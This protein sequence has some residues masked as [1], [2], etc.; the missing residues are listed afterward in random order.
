[1]LAAVLMTNMS[2]KEMLHAS[3]TF[4]NTEALV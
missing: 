2:Q 1:M 3:K 4:E